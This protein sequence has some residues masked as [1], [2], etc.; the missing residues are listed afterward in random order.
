MMHK[1]RRQNFAALES[2]LRLFQV[3]DVC[4][5]AAIVFVVSRIALVAQTSLA[6]VS[7]SHLVPILR[8]YKYSTCC[9]FVLSTAL[10]VRYRAK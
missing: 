2:Q 9:R 7:G 6:L 10:V 8:W 5:H 4:N 1:E 3:D